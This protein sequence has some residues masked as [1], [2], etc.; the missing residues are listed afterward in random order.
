MTVP[1]RREKE[2]VTDRIRAQETQSADAA[3]GNLLVLFANWF[4]TMV[5]ASCVAALALSNLFWTVRQNV[6]ALSAQSEFFAFSWIYGLRWG[7]GEFVFQPHSQL[8]YPVFSL[9]DKIF[10]MTA[11]SADQIIAGWHRV[12]FVWPITVM[13]A[14]LVL[15]FVTI[16]RRRPLLDAVLSALIYLVSIPLFLPDQALSSLSYHSISVPLALGA[17][18]FWNCYRAFPDR[19][20]RSLFYICLGVYAAICV[21][22]KPTFI[23]FAAPLF[24]ME[25]VKAA[26]DQSTRHLGNVFLGVATAVFVY[27]LWLLLFYGNIKGVKEHVGLSYQFM[28]TQAGMYDQQKGATPFH[29]YFNYV[30]GVMGP[31]PTILI[32]S[33]SAISFLSRQRAVLLYGVGTSVMLALFFLYH[34]SQSHGHPEF[35]AALLATTIGCFRSSGLLEELDR[36]LRLVIRGPIFSAVVSI[37]MIALLIGCYPLKPSSE[38]FSAVMAEYDAIVVPNLFEQPESVR[39]IALMEYPQVFWGVGDAWCRGGGDIFDAVRSD[40][41]DKKFGNVTCMINQETSAA[42]RPEFN[43]VVFVKSAKT[44]LAD[45]FVELAKRFPVVSSR[46]GECRSLGT[47]HYDGSEFFECPLVDKWSTA[48]KTSVDRRTD[49][50]LINYKL[51]AESALRIKS[52]EVEFSTMPGMTR[53][54]VNPAEMK[55]VEIAKDGEGSFNLRSDFSGLLLVRGRATTARNEG[56]WL[57]DLWVVGGGTDL[58]LAGGFSH[59]PQTIVDTSFAG[60]G[61]VFRASGWSTPENW[62][63]WSIDDAATLTPIAKPEWSEESDFVFEAEVRAFIASPNKFQAVRMRANSVVV[64]D[65]LFTPSNPER[66]IRA[67]IPRRIL[68]NSNTINLLFETPDSVSPFSLG[69]SSDTRKLG[70]GFKRFKV[71]E[72]APFSPMQS[73][74]E[75]SLSRVT[76]GGSFLTAGWSTSR[77]T[78]SLATDP[79]A[80]LLVPMPEGPLA[81]ATIAIDA[82]LMDE[83]DRRDC[84]VDVSTD[85]RLIGQIRATGTVSFDLPNDL[86]SPGK[87]LL[88]TFK[89]A[90][91]LG[92]TVDGANRPRSLPLLLRDIRIDWSRQ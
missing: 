8:I 84:V 16:D 39:T 18:P 43:R 75:V 58:G 52:I 14:G 42:V 55:V 78:G 76:D 48:I 65:W 51:V 30:I 13:S 89:E 32:V 63:T 6:P 15:L 85:G 5:V 11:G 24:A 25:L 33:A 91:S 36:R 44:S 73:P 12:S 57:E 82:N 7:N 68:A 41:L 81:H 29:W 64:A 56:D 87:P 45:N 62:G 69:L 20:F 59:C 2:V 27:L 34:R 66:V 49:K 67:L 74:E 37:G 72:W 4:A 70:I 90:V 60:S 26:R 22:G 17:L 53:C 28:V 88:I 21:L 31:L 77:E 40:F 61:A 80:A 92:S 9:I 19:G 50:F 38:G 83:G 71:S 10:S 35:I 54:D 23:A 86:L 3:P 47:V 79:T 46:M 1:Q